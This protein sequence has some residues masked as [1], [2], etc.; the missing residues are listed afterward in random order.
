MQD[1]RSFLAFRLV[2]QLSSFTAAAERMGLTTAAVSKMVRRLETELDTPLLLRT[3]RRLS[4]TMEGRLFFAAVE[5]MLAAMETGHDQ[6][7]E[8]RD[9][10]AGTVKL[11]T[12]SAIGR[13]YVVPMLSGF[14]KRYPLIEVEMR[15][16]DRM[17][18]LLMEGFDL[19]IEHSSA[20]TSAHG[21]P[22]C[23]APLA[24]VASPA[25][26][27]RHG[28]PATPEELSSLDCVITK[29]PG[30]LIWEFRPRSRVNGRKRSSPV[31]IEPHGRVS[32][33]GQYDSVL[34]AAIAGLGVTVLFAH[35]IEQHVRAGRLRVL[36]PQWTVHSGSASSLIYMHL[37]MTGRLPFNVKVLVDYLSE[38]FARV[39]RA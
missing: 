29:V 8:A 38:G 28:T 17:P 12:N 25:F 21:K 10:P 22:L 4:M 39:A 37:P 30:K 35:S 18:D 11:W 16:D 20:G 32:V 24:V 2:A 34:D 3:T 27:A 23:E 31:L 14:L 9:R 15:C 7:R 6:L 26:L 33:S 5:R 19:A 36:L 1:L 13:H